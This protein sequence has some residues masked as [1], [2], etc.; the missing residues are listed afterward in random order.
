MSLNVSSSILFFYFSPIIR[1]NKKR[2]IG[3]LSFSFSNEKEI[4]IE[5]NIPFSLFEK[6]SKLANCSF[7]YDD[8]SS[9]K[10]D[11]VMSQFNS[12]MD[13][14]SSSEIYDKKY[15]IYKSEVVNDLISKQDT[16][17]LFLSQLS[18]PYNYKVMPSII[19]CIC[20]YYTNEKKS[21][22]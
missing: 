20:H 3:P 5:G 18:V 17:D 22:S 14:F 10:L 6:L 9:P 16:S 8:F 11:K 1:H 19:K 4:L 21:I 13:F 12:V 15:S 2:K 7:S